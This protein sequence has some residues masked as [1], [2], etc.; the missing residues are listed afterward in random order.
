M[1]WRAC[2]LL[3]A[4]LLGAC[5][6]GPETRRLQQETTAVEL[7]AV[8]FFP[9][10]DYQCGPAALATVLHAAGVPAAPE[11][12]VDEVYIPARKGSLQTE[13]VAAVR[14]RGQVPYVLEPRID[15]ALVELRAGHPVLVLQNLGTSLL[16]VWHYAVV[17]GYDP[18]AETFTLRSGR[19]PRLQM[20]AARFLQ[21]WDR[22]GRWMLVIAAPEAPPPSATPAGWLRA[23]AP[24][25]S[26]GRLDLA[27]RAYTAALSRWPDSAP[28]WAALGT[29]QARRAE[30]PAALAA[31]DRALALQPHAPFVRNNYA[32][33]LAQA[34][35]RTR[36]LAQVQQ[37]LA[38]AGPG[39]RGTLEQ[40]L[41]EIEA[42][43]AGDAALCAAYA[44]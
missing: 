26:L 29:V 5:A 15:A 23:A 18:V 10:E 6:A 37:A 8:P 25:E 31:Y 30:L 38:Q 19:E 44:P 2:A 27:L 11:A 32:W 16:P 24:F 14:R 34:G 41:R 22:G 35:C 33:T 4:A 40:T 28:A 3:T 7:S 36:A 43:T 20:A 39:E 21:S 17:V 42:Q 1:R 12:L 9:Q 13:L